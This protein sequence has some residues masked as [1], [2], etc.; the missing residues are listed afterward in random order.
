MRGALKP[1]G[2]TAVSWA[3]LLPSSWPKPSMAVNCF[4]S[5]LLSCWLAEGRG[6][7]TC[8]DDTHSKSCCDL[9]LIMTNERISEDICPRMSQISLGAIAQTQRRLCFHLSQAG[10]AALLCSTAETGTG[11]ARHS[12]PLSQR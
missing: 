1:H 12:A 6:Q 11:S 3:R 2:C 8:G 4:L 7:P 9:L 5:W 10:E